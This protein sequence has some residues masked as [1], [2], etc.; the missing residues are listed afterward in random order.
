MK[1]SFLSYNLPEPFGTAMD[2]LDANSFLNPV[3]SSE[4]GF[5]DRSPF[6]IWKYK[7]GQFWY[8]PRDSKFKASS[9]G[10]A[11]S[12]WK[13]MPSRFSKIGFFLDLLQR[14]STDR[15]ICSLNFEVN[16]SNTLCCTLFQTFAISAESLTRKILVG[17]K[18]SCLDYGC[19]WEWC[20]MALKAQL[21]MH[22]F[23]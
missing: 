7:P 19:Y 9:A 1:R 3:T 15:F 12:G 14:T 13:N 17:N 23:H 22:E 18:F 5:I 16:N 10:K 6:Q 21:L 4:E 20:F 8:L 11:K 2:S